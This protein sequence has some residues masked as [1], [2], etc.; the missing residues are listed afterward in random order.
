ME[1]IFW[2]LLLHGSGKTAVLVE[3]MIRK[4]TEKNI[5]IDID[6][7]LVV[8][9]TN[10]AASQMREKILE[11]IYKKL[12]DEPNNSHL[13]KQIVLMNKANI[14][15]I[16]SFCL[17][18]IR[19]HFYEIGISPNFR[20]GDSSELE[21]LQQETIED[22][23]EEKYEEKN[24]EFL[25]LTENY[26]TYRGD[27]DLKELVFR[28]HRF[29]QSTPFPED[30]LEE[31]TDRF[32]VKDK[33]DEDFSKTIWGEI[34]LENMQE[35]AQGYCLELNVLEKKLALEGL[36]KYEQ[37]VREDRQKIQEF[38]NIKTWEEAYIKANSTSFSSW[39][40]DKKIVSN[41][42]EEAKLKRTKIKENFQASI[43]NMKLYSSKEAMQDIAFMFPTLVAL[44]NLIIDFVLVD[45]YNRLNIN[46]ILLK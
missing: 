24:A 33:M 30:W 7:L 32:N 26:A 45:I 5:D 36:T 20:M 13:Q 14:S 35:E 34:L 4:L 2:L 1:K 17:E 12:E 39:P 11:A 28:I 10:A 41:L 27:D 25:K 43:E 44:K 19:N 29:V 46:S 40:I 37:T 38:I 31:A 15:T 9:F 8:T 21:L 6:R 3:R 18:V 23:F 42:K 16:H 22:L